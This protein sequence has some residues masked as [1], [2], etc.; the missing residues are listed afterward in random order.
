MINTDNLNGELEF[1]TTSIIQQY[2]DDFKGI[3]KIKVTE[4][5]FILLKK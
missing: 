4:L 1:E 5:L 2:P 3:G